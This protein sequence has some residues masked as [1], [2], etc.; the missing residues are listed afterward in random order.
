MPP[1]AKEPTK[2]QLRNLNYI[3]PKTPSF[4]TNFK[5]QIANG[6]VPVPPASSS[7]VTD[8]FGRARAGGD[9]APLVVVVD[10]GKHLSREEMENERRRGEFLL[11]LVVA[12][13]L[14]REGLRADRLLYMLA[15]LYDSQ[16]SSTDILI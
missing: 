1:K 9:D 10:E 6:G 7:G 2:N 12:T 4:L 3:H 14:L 8:E 13:S 5:A 15:L 16:R 11:S